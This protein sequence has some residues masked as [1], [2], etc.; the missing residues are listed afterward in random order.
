MRK[1]LFG[2]L[3]L[4][5]D[6]LSICTSIT[7][8]FL[9]KFKSLEMFFSEQLARAPF[10][11]IILWVIFIPVIFYI[12][13][14]YGLIFYA[15]GIRIVQ[16]ILAG[17]FTAG[18][19]V[20]VFTYLFLHIFIGRS[21]FAL[22]L[23]FIMLFTTI[24]R[25]GFR[26]IQGQID[27]SRNILVVG[28]KGITSSVA[29][30]LMETNRFFVK[31]YLYSDASRNDR[32]LEEI[33]KAKNIEV[34]FFDDPKMPDDIMQDL[35]QCRVKGIPVREV[36]DFY[37]DEW[38][39]IPVYHLRDRWFVYSHGFT[40][41]HHIFYQRVKRII[42]IVFSILTM[43]AMGPLMFVTA[44]LIK[45]ESKGPVFYKQ[46]RIGLNER[47]YNLIKFR[48]MIK[49]AE[50]SGAVWAEEK[51]SRLTKVGRFMRPF[52]I[53]ELPQLFNILKGNMSF[54]GPRPERP[55]FIEELK[56]VIPYY[57][58]RHLVNPGL[59]GWA[60]VNYP[61]GASVE[62]AVRKLGYDLYYIKNS[63]FLL[64]LQI[65]LRTFRVVL[66]RKGSR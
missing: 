15:S 34:I 8:T 30:E 65:V 56:K 13:E 42:D 19:L 37:E 63:N 62:D 47:T 40:V 31:K 48:S 11:D 25:L 38:E 43:I 52:R 32:L 64:D 3:F 41:I 20:A 21:L 51:D 59:T 36:V 35:M 53:D 58:Y 14:L 27:R 49:D 50:K 46:M 18:I 60:Q 12:L 44:A 26:F 61:Y 28:P 54:I 7:L 22:H 57:S 24:W 29:D 39:K 10:D 16:R 33:S 55:I 23:L 6:I 2:F 5:L 66:L 1:I 45:I 4:F 9:I 17:V